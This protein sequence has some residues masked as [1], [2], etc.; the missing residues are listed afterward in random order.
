[1]NAGTGETVWRENRFGKGNLVAADN[2][3]WMTTMNGEFVVAEASASGYVELGRTKLFGKTRQAP[4][5][6]GGKAYV[7]DDA[8]VICIKID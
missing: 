1:V 5:I 4:S 8:E 2:K 7:R 6:A 3:L